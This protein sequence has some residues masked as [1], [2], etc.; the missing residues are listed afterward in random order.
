MTVIAVAENAENKLVSLL[1]RSAAARALALVASSLI[2]FGVCVLFCFVFA[3]PG[4]VRAAALAMSG[5][6]IAGLLSTFVGLF[7]RG[8]SKALFRLGF[9]MVIR[10]FGL[11]G[12]ALFVHFRAPQLVDSGFIYFL[13][14]FYGAEL[15]IETAML[16]GDISNVKPAMRSPNEVAG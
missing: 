3:V 1:R 15:S 11:L 12:L 5:C 14:V 7:F 4:G 9:G 10:M 6:L 16:L 2:L 8:E 13:L